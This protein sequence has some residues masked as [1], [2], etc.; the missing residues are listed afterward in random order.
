MTEDPSVRPRGLQ[1]P[2]FRLATLLIVLSIICAGLAA[3]RVVD[4]LM[5]AV[6]TLFGLAIFAHV[7]GNSWGTQLRQNSSRATKRHNSPESLPLRPAPRTKL[8]LHT[9]L[10][11]LTLIVTAIGVITGGICGGWLLLWLLRGQPVTLLSMGVGVTSFATLGGFVG[12]W[13]SSLLTILTEAIVQ[14]HRESNT[15]REGKLVKGSK[16]HGGS[17]CQGAARR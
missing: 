10:G 17:P 13:T 11:W 6:A 5:A 4:P 2:R 1:P 16:L 9:R 15:N 14:A 7:A 12:F 8:A 3:L